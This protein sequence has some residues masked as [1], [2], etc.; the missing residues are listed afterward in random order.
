MTDIKDVKTS[1]TVSNGLLHTIA[2]GLNIEG[3]FPA[4]DAGSAKWANLVVVLDEPIKSGVT[5]DELIAG[6]RKER[7]P[8]L[9]N[10]VVELDEPKFLTA[11]TAII[12]YYMH[13]HKRITIHIHQFPEFT[14][15]VNIVKSIVCDA[16]QHYGLDTKVDIRTDNPFYSKQTYDTD[17]LISL[18]QCAGLNPALV[19]GSLLIPTTFIPFDCKSV[20]ISETY[21]ATNILTADINNILK[22][23]YHEY[24]AKIMRAYES[25]NAQK[26]HVPRALTESDFHRDSI[27]LQTT[28]IWNPKDPNKIIAVI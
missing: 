17:L 28:A 26:K 22:S 14:G 6:V 12:V 20:K 21:S 9:E 4:Q 1:K 3:G 24:A 25:A 2:D 18:S 5:F 10:G 23:K 19:P 27:I 8:I 11:W 16:R 15:I 7:F 13:I